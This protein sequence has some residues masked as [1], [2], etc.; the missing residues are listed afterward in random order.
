MS[1]TRNQKLET[2]NVQAVV[3]DFDGTL[4]K[5]N[6]DF[7]LMRASVLDLLASY[8]GATDGIRH[9]FVLEMIEAGKNI[10]EADHPATGRDFYRRA[11]RLIR[12]IE[13]EAARRGELIRGIKEMLCHLQARNIRIGVASRNCREA[14]VE[15]FSDID[16]FCQAVIT[17]EAT[18]SVKPH[19]VHL[20]TVLK[21]LRA[22][23]RTS[24]MVG[25][26]PM[27]IQVG[28][29]VG[30]L[31]VGVLTGYS[32]ADALA[33]AG[34]DLIIESAADIIHHLP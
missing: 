1:S 24:V 4:A 13:V 9:L 14:V 26:H 33:A 34:A 27:D 2:R 31:T 29:K 16:A 3:F 10:L 25:D 19:P 8:G 23:A 28:K 21:N 12:D 20:R 30:T 7:P 5:L 17:R 15:V 11:C 18:R 22:R 6:I 32:G